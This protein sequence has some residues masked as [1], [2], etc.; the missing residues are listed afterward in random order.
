MMLR[1][2]E[3]VHI[4]LRHDEDLQSSRDGSM[5]ATFLRFPE[6]KNHADTRLSVMASA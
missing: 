6:E 3:I 2:Q 4:R 5:I 1:G